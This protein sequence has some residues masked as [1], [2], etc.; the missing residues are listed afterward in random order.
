LRG[1]ALAF[2]ERDGLQT[3]FVCGQAAAG[4]VAVSPAFAFAAQ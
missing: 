4:V 2:D 1:Q 3:C